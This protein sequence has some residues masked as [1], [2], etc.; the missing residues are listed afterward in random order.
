[1]A[2]KLPNPATVREMLARAAATLE[3]RGEAELIAGLALRR[4][5]AWLIAHDDAR[6]DGPDVERFD[7]LVQERAEGMPIA[8][9]AGTRE[10]YGREFRVGPA[11]LIPRPETEHLVEW[12]LALALPAD[13]RVIDVGTGSGCIILTLA[14]ERPGWHCTGTDI[15]AAALAVAAENRTL[16]DAGRVRLLHGDLLEPV[17]ERGV[18]LIVSN[19]PY[20][21]A[22]DPHLQQGDVRFEPEIALSDGTDGLDTIR[23]LIDWADRLLAP[24]GWL[25]LEH[26]Y[27]QAEAVR[28][29]FRKGGYEQVESKSD[30]A[31]IERVTGGRIEQA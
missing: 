14:A 19:P 30:L 5:R 31:G 24:G 27:D 12:A 25:L 10:F 17:D 16:L 28:E 26:G 18:D 29:L 21:A 7:L 15:S 11:V 3:S 4:S 8:Y 2:T 9:L 1:M 23:R 6:V 22:G 13:A 20:V